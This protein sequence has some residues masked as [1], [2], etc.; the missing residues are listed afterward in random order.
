MSFRFFLPAKELDQGWPA[1][2]R[3]LLHALFYAACVLVGVLSLLPSATLPPA[4]IGD[5][6]EHVIAYAVLALFGCA[7]FE[8][9]RTTM[10]LGL[11]AYGAVLELLQS[12]APGRSP[13]I[14]DGVADL[15]GACLGGGAAI[16]LRRA[17]RG[18]VDKSIGAA[19]E[20]R[21]CPVGGGARRGARPQQA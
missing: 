8:R 21:A 20:S 19:T 18:A 3:R 6:A 11:A 14:A 5:K 10:I 13:E 12:L 16:V 4:A 2:V 17:M 1:R 15:I 9:R 7:L